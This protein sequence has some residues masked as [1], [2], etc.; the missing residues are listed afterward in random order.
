MARGGT[1]AKA[2]KSTA[3][4]V[5]KSS[6]SKGGGANED[7]RREAPLQAVLFADSFAETFRPVTLETPK[8]LLPLN[9]VPMLEYALEFLASGGVRE[10]I[11]FCTRHVEQLERF[12]RER[13]QVARRLAVLCVSSPSCLTAGDALRE[14]DRQQLVRSNPFVLMSGDVVANV[15]L[16]AALEEHKARKKLD[17]TTMMT[18]IFKEIQPNCSTSIRPLTDEL[19]VGVDSATS[20][21]VL[22]EDDPAKRATRLATIF[23]EAHAQVALRSDL[24]DCFID[25]CSTEVLLKFAEDFDYQDLRRDFYHNEVQN[26]ELGNKFFV[27]IVTDEFAARVVDPR[28]YSGISH[29]IL[30]RWVFPMVPDTNYLGGDDTTYSYHRGMVYKEDAVALS[31]TCVIGRQSILG[32]GSSF[33]DYTSVRKSAVGRNC[34]IGKHVTIEGSFLWSNV[35]VEDGA[36]ITNA[37][38]CDNVVVRKGAV[39]EEG[40]V[41]SF[42]VVIGEGFTLKAFS[43]VTKAA[44]VEQDDEFASSDDDEDAASDVGNS[45]T[46]TTTAAAGGVVSTE[47]GAMVWSA[48]DVGVGGVGRLWTLDDDDIQ[49][50]SDD[51]SDGDGAADGK[52]TTKPPSLAARRLEKLKSMLIGAA[53]V[54]QKQTQ[55]WND[56]ETLSLSDDEDDDLDGLDDLEV[57]EAPF[58]QIIKENV[59]NGDAAGHA[60]E[61]VFMEIKSSKFAHNRSF[62]DVIGA[63][64]PGLLEL[65]ATE[66]QPAMGILGHVRGKFHKWS[67]IIK[68]CLVEQEDQVA[69]VHTLEAFCVADAHRGVWSPLFRFLLQIVYD[70]EWVSDDVILE[71]H[72]ERVASGGAGG[73]DV[74]NGGNELLVALAKSAQ[75][76]EF[77]DW[78]QEEE[79]EDD[80]D[81]SDD[82]DSE[83]DED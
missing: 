81:E 15:D 57:H 71:W 67:S 68:K 47:P 46:A 20:Q 18:S 58:H 53:D 59:M 44:H 79:E 50:D 33:G 75:V 63:M 66:G 56:W 32:A 35:V 70:L 40:C 9:N 34:A 45:T 76:Q 37:I 1:S 29:A 11:L 51:E 22:Y 6:K 78:L 62:A 2:P 83:S 4:A 80:D 64:V 38:L 74:D 52:T 65:V 30:Q 19:I 26:Y 14:I 41:L 21:I 43:K 82:E 69:V 24:M 12:V 61:D 10:V 49:V 54:V 27:K 28:T 23:L 31:R 60:V 17:A 55:K 73:H 39:I 77:I 5:G 25:I 13:S 48:K 7:V 36:R 42:G 72:A 8:V 3:T 16:P